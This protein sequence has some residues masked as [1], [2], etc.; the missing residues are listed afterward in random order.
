MSWAG[1]GRG[2]PDPKLKTIVLPHP[3]ED[4][5]GP[6]EAQSG[7]FRAVIRSLSPRFGPK[8]ELFF[9]GLG[10]FAALLTQL[11]ALQKIN[12][13]GSGDRDCGSDTFP[14]GATQ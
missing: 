11:G 6:K 8:L 5:T 10:H 12:A 3:P 9:D 7:K 4:F 13:G 14:L 1:I 2:S